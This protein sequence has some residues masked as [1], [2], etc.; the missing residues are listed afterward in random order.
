[1]IE[2]FLLMFISIKSS[3]DTTTC[4]QKQRINNL[5]RDRKG[6]RRSN[7][8]SLDISKN[9]KTFSS[10]DA[11]YA[12]ARCSSSLMRS[13]PRCHR[14]IMNCRTSRLAPWQGSAVALYFH[15]VYIYSGDGRNCLVA[16]RQMYICSRDVSYW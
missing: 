8:L 3:I 4:W 11:T 10:N 9:E 5:F 14:K 7:F 15:N 13:P 12:W 6:R 1:L 16:F 2:F